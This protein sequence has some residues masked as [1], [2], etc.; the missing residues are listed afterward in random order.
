MRFLDG[1]VFLA[2]PAVT[3]TRSL[4]GMLFWKCMV[5]AALGLCLPILPGCKKAESPVARATAEQIL[6][7]NNNAEPVSLDPQLVAGTSADLRVVSA[8]FEGLLVNDPQSLV[9]SPGVATR[10]EISPDGLTYSFHLRPE[11]CW[12]D[13][14]PLTAHDF[15]FSSRRALTPQLAA[16]NAAFF[17]SV[18]NARAYYEG[19]I[20]DFAAVGFA[21]PDAHTLQIT[22]EYPCPYFL[23]LLCHPVWS[24]VP[25][26]AIRAAGEI[27]VPN[28]PWTRPGCLVSN[29]AF[30][31]KTWKIADRIEVER[32]PRYWNTAAVRLNGIRFLAIGDLLAEERAFRGGLLHLTSTV[33]PMK[34]RAL[35]E[36]KS[37]FLRL[38]PFFSTTFVRVN[39]RKKPL[40]DPRVRRALALA[41]Q[42]EEIAEYVMRAG[43]KP[44]FALTPS[45]A[46]DYTCSSPLQENV[47]EA[48][49]LLAEAG[50]PEGKN[51][52]PLE[53][54]YN[55]HETSQLIAQALQEMWQKNLGIAV[56]LLSQE[57]KVYKHA[58]ASGD[59]QLARS[60]WSGDYFDPSSFLE[61]FSSASEQNQTGWSD[62]GYD[63]ALARAA[64]SVSPVVRRAAF[65]NAEEKLLAAMPVIPLVHNTNKFLIRPEVRGWHPNALDIHPFTAVWLEA[66]ETR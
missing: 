16:P 19:K 38:D 66:E 24:P 12:S 2:L 50:Y 47:A 9:P 40:D 27:A 22:L 15:L 43:E 11:A 6:L 4:R 37:P 36:E 54:L 45:G 18:K 63:D 57:W 61:L 55:Q 60:A 7:V 23:A 35:R 65:Q 30:Q 44:A 48:Q 49:R 13:G 8:L 41:V 64:R 21:A 42:R 34:V 5:S 39:T 46:A 51:F 59:Y 17:F 1:V 29:G 10:W 52:P 28:T 62:P 53:Y 14:T 33:P 26:H 3:Q 32:N 58:L 25:E 31:L 20:T 56:G